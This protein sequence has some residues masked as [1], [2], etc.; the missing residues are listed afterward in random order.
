MFGDRVL[1]GRRVPK[2]EDVAEGGGF[3]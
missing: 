2:R 3:G 1:R